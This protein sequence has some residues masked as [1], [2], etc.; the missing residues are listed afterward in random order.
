[1]ASTS[2]PA[3]RG[4]ETSIALADSLVAAPDVPD[5]MEPSDGE[6]DG[7]E[8]PPEVPGMNCPGVPGT[9]TAGVDEP[10]VEGVVMPVDGVVGG[11]VTPPVLNGGEALAVAVDRPMVMVTVAPWSRPGRVGTM[12]ADGGRG[13]ALNSVWK[14]VSSAGREQKPAE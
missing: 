4:L 1:M 2:A 13:I 11:G 14:T 12:A 8:P 6:I 9:L 5:G 7:E 3:P 10:G